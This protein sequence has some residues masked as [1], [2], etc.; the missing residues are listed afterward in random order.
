MSQTRKRKKV[1]EA[2]TRKQ[3]CVKKKKMNGEGK[4]DIVSR[5]WGHGLL[6]RLEAGCH[7]KPGSVKK[8][9]QGC[10]NQHTRP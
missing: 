10:L 4:H 3:V 1:N 6:N 9:E 2:K 8:H 7:G 5:R